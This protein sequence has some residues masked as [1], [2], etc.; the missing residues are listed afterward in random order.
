MAVWS[1]PDCGSFS[2][3]QASTDWWVSR[4]YSAHKLWTPPPF[5]YMSVY[6]SG[7]NTSVSSFNFTYSIILVLGS[8]GVIELSP[9]LSITWSQEQSHLQII[10]SIAWLFR[11]SWLKWYTLLESVIRESRLLYFILTYNQ[12][13]LLQKVKLKIIIIGNN[14]TFAL[15]LECLQ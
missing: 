4:L 2:E 9:N 14:Y 1:F 5:S 6:V 10:Q 7:H 13:I 15:R 3:N 12:I 8:N 11:D